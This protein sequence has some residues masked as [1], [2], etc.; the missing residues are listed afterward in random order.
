VTGRGE[1]VPRGWL[2]PTCQDLNMKTPH[3]ILLSLFI[4]A[5]CGTAATA[6]SRTGRIMRQKLA[7]SQKIVEA[8]LTSDFG[9]L[10]RESAA[11]GKVT[12]SSAWTSA[13]RGPEYVRQSDAFLKTLRDLGESGRTHDLDA[14][15]QQYTAMTMTC[16]S[17]HRHMKDQRIAGL[18]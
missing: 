18:R 6:Q 2:R 10:A 1:S 13:L 5:L 9:L 12:E 4:V 16:F 11:L 3:R 17:C 7:H 8:I 14:A 15:A